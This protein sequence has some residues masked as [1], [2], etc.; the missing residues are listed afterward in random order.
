MTLYFQREM[1]GY[2]NDLYGKIIYIKKNAYM[3]MYNW[4][5]LPYIWN[6]YNTENNYTPIKN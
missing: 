3:Y 6:Q 5:I 4:F 2:C 1:D